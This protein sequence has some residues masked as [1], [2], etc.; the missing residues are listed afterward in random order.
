MKDVLQNSWLKMFKNHLIIVLL[1]FLRESGFLYLFRW[2]R[3][4]TDFLFVLPKKGNIELRRNLSRIFPQFGL[5]IES[6]S[7]VFWTV[8]KRFFPNFFWREEACDVRRLRGLVLWVCITDFHK[9]LICESLIC[10]VSENL[11]SSIQNVYNILRK[12]Y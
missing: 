8:I 4:E 2:T 1:N 10:R 5:C 7:F 12:W 3:A 9:A 6:L 11:M